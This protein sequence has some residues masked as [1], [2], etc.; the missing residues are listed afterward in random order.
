MLS[1]WVCVCVRF[2]LLIWCCFIP[3]FFT[4]CFIFTLSTLNL[5][6]QRKCGQ[7]GISF[8]GI[9]Y[10][11]FPSYWGINMANGKRLFLKAW[12]YLSYF[13]ECR[14][15]VGWQKQ[16]ARR[17]NFET[18]QQQPFVWVCALDKF[19]LVF[20]RLGTISNCGGTE[21]ET[22]LL[23]ECIRFLIFVCF[24]MELMSSLPR[25][26]SIRVMQFNFHGK[27]KIPNPTI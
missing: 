22:K 11:A 4:S 21:S 12:S 19:L 5:I 6:S 14:L 9:L 13:S 25:H 26:I 7:N 15:L 24:C 20:D 8:N 17:C 2:F 23:D 3:Q 18:S 1:Y 10:S 27:Y 16:T